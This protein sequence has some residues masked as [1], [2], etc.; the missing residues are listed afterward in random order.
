MQ[1]RGLIVLAAVAVLSVALAAAAVA[2]GDRYASSA[3]ADRKAFPA[4]AGEL[5]QVASVGLERQGLAVTFRRRGENWLVVQ[6][7]GYPAAAGRVREIALALADMRL[8]EPKTRL[9]ALY[10]RL[11]VE[12]PGH[13]MATLVTVADGS[14][15][16]LARLI[17]GKRRFDRLGEGHAGVYVRRPGDAQSWLASGDLDLSG[18]LASWLDRNIVDIP[19]SRIARLRLVQPDGKALVLSRKTPGDRFMVAD[20]PAD[21]T[22]KGETATNEPA[23]ALAGLDLD[24]VA[25]AATVPV[26]TSGV[27]SV[28]FTTFDGLEIDLRLV[29]KGKTAW[30]AVAAGGSGKAAAEAKRI[31]ARVKGWSYA[32]PADKA[33]MIKTKFSD[34]V[35]LQKGS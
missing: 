8:V 33:A 2:T 3:P 31:E 17:V 32:I 22:Y 10:P 18:E 26:P 35:S 19:D 9:A 14:G 12:D 16:S 30:V 1:K 15:G 4:L 21:T 11:E 34:L 29:D 13:G 27:M 25:P 20:A 5:G 24:D 6:K 7:A 28:A 23:M